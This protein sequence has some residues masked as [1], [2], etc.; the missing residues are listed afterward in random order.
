[1]QFLGLSVFFRRIPSG[2]VIVGM[3]QRT[4]VGLSEGQLH[5]SHKKG[6]RI[7]IFSEHFC[8][9]VEIFNVFC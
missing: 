1:M 2:E 3:E 5:A 6:L 8:D 7:I 9:C 4:F